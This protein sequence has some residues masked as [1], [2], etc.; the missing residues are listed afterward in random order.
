MQGFDI[1]VDN[2]NEDHKQVIVPI[3]HIEL[4]A[5]PQFDTPGQAVIMGNP[6]D[7]SMFYMCQ[8]GRAVQLSCPD[9]M[10]WNEAVKS[11]DEPHRGNCG[12]HF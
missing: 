9:N 7:C 4:S 12:A 3:S 1:Q 6:E 8:D 5:C 11:C 2:T 10:Q